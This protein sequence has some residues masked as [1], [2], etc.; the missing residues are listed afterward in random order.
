MCIFW[1]AMPQWADSASRASRQRHRHS[2]TPFSPQPANVSGNCRFGVRPRR[3][4]VSNLTLDIAT[5]LCAALL[6]VRLLLS[7]PRRRSAQLI[8]LISVCNICYV[9][10]SRFEYGFWIPAPFHFEVSGWFDVLNFARNLAPGLLM[11]LCFT[12]FTEG[13]R[14]PG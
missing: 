8:A 9:A 14:F 2:P 6:G 7:Y 11:I 12:L 3:S 13:Q 5:M 4:G 10:L 1:R